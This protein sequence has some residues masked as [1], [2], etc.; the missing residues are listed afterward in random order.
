MPKTLRFLIAFLLIAFPAL[1][2]V[3]NP[4]LWTTDGQV[5]TTAID[6]NTMYLG[7]NFNYIG[8][9]T[10][11][12]LR[13]TAGEG[14]LITGKLPT[15]DVNVNA[16][17]PDGKGGFY[18]SGNFKIGGQDFTFLHVGADG[19]VD[20]NWKP[21]FRITYIGAFR[22]EGSTLYAAGMH[23]DESGHNLNFIAALD[24]STGKTLW[25][26]V[27]PGGGG[28]ETTLAVNGNRVY[29]GGGFQNA[30]VDG[31]TRSYLF[32]LEAGTGKMTSWNPAPGGPVVTIDALDNTVYVGGQ[33]HYMS[34]QV[35]LNLAALD[36]NTGLLHDWNPGLMYKEI[37]PTSQSSSPGSVHKLIAS[38][39]EI[40]VGGGFNWI[41]GEYRNNL[42]SVDRAT[43]K[44]TAWNPDVTRTVDGKNLQSG[45]VRIMS[46]AE[47]QLYLYGDFNTVNGQSRNGFAAVDT[48]T[49][50][51]TAWNPK[52]V[53]DK[54]YNQFVSVYTLCASGNE[55]FI[56]GS[57]N[58]FTMLPRKNLAAID[59]ATDQLTAWSPAPDGY[60]S[61][62]AIAN[63]TLLVQGSFR[64]IN[65]QARALLAG[66]D[67]VTG[68]VN[69]WNIRLTTEYDAFPR[70]ASIITA[71][72]NTFYV[73][74]DF[75]QVNGLSRKYLCAIDAGTGSVT[76]WN[77]VVDASI[78]SLSISENKLYLFGSFTTINGQSRPRLGSV[79]VQSGRVTPWNPSLGSVPIRSIVAYKDL[80]YV[81]GEFSTIGN[82]DRRFVA[83]VSTITG[84]VTSWNPDPD[85]IVHA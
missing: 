78:T 63:K 81:A 55:V 20:A 70:S 9:H 26:H 61:G 4:T 58:C 68:A 74:G 67:L 41:G 77:P 45:S 5:F 19:Q 56:G 40:I 3:P 71:Y 31:Q 22:L 24:W 84:R 64:Q 16:S 29:V 27:L 32:S 13:V 1:S 44:A 36:A 50:A 72:D 35:R 30:Q 46:L 18:L 75:T 65:G 28:L 14:D 8:Y 85:R 42:A 33:F 39:T 66:L 57:F 34:G 62:M 6:K 51:A 54:A 83:A 60:V 37:T 43:G 52:K 23:T 38:R 69:P 17:Q 80:V 76:A 21:D 15:L 11:S 7:G 12:G 53:D 49:G 48:R 59:M 82:A 79:D 10:G 73:S 2:Q 47:N 25:R